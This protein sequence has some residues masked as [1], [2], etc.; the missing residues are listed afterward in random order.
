VNKRGKEAKRGNGNYEDKDMGAYMRNAILLLNN[1]FTISRRESSRDCRKS[2]LD[3]MGDTGL[4]P[5][6]SSL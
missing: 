6:T 5:V 3:I 2:L 4:E 1:Y